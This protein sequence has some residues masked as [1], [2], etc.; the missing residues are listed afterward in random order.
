MFKIDA[1]VKEGN[2][3]KLTSYSAFDNLCVRRNKQ[4]RMVGSV[5]KFIK[6]KLVLQNE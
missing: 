3:K 5:Y 2:R 4:L 1:F 6:W